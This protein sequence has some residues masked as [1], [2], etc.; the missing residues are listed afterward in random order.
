MKGRLLFFS[1]AILCGVVTVNAQLIRKK[2]KAAQMKVGTENILK[3]RP[4][5]AVERVQ[6]ASAEEYT[7][8]TER[9]L[10]SRIIGMSMT[11][12][13]RLFLPLLYIP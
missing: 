9:F 7:V 4:V 5:L 6:P 2:G 12:R 3:A 10:R 13:G 11:Q 8:I 1:M